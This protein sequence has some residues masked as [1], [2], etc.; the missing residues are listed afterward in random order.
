MSEIIIGNNGI[1][2]SGDWSMTCHACGSTLNEIEKGVEFMCQ[3]SKCAYPGFYRV[4]NG[5][6]TMHGAYVRAGK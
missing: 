5:K 3:N 6:I 2:A 1:Q 4:K